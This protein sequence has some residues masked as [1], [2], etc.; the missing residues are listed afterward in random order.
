MRI[1]AHYYNLPT[2]HKLRLIIVLTVS[3]ALLLASAAVL[4]YDQ[5]A[6]RIEMRSELEVLAEI[7][8]SNSTAAL[9]FGDERAAEDV[10]AG[11][12]AKRHISSAVIDSADGRLFASY[13]AKPKALVA[14]LAGRAYGSWFEAGRLIAYKGIEL[15]RQNI[16]SVYLESDTLELRARFTRFGCVTLVIL[17][18]AAALALGL[19]FRLQRVVSVPIA[20]LAEVAKAVSDR[21]NYSVRATKRADDDLGQLVDTFN[22]M[23]SEI[24]FRDAA[25]LGRLNE[26]NRAQAELVHAKDAAEE[27]NRAKS[28]FLATMSHELRTPLNAIIG[29]SQMLTEDYIGPEQEEVRHDLEK[30]ERSGHNLL[31]IINDI[32]DLSKIES[33]REAVKAE[34]F[35][36]AP[37]LEDIC[38]TLQPMARQQGNVLEIDCPEHARLVYADLAKFRQ[39]V[40]NLVNNACKFTENGRVTVAVDRR[41]SPDGEWTEVHVSDTGIGIGA[42]DLSKLFRPFSQVDGSCTRKYNGTGLGLAISRKFCRMMGGDITVESEPG[43]GACFTIRLPAGRTIAGLPASAP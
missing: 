23:L 30:I 36:V 11:L 6:S 18:G 13:G 35:D 42:Q 19:S 7:V 8:G 20:H 12:K 10:L 41:H 4:T 1:A 2:G 14:P 33:G 28:V 21:R 22:G 5:I 27:A 25:L 3:V 31:G 29:Y 43:R 32:L 34:T 40:L 24:E 39:S 16:G 15:R 38:G 9:T 17:L 37:V 26:L